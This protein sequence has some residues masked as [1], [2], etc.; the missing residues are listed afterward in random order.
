MSYTPIVG[1]FTIPKHNF[2]S[3]IFS[4]KGLVGKSNDNT[5]SVS[6]ITVTGDMEDSNNK[7]L[8]IKS[9]NPFTEYSVSTLTLTT[10]NS[11]TIAESTASLIGTSDISS[12]TDAATAIK[13]SLLALKAGFELSLFFVEITSSG[14]VVTLTYV[15]TAGDKPNNAGE[16][17]GTLI[18]EGTV[19]GVGFN[20][21]LLALNRRIFHLMINETTRIG[22]YDYENFLKV[23]KAFF[24]RAKGL[25]TG[26]GYASDGY[27]SPLPIS[28][29][30][31]SNIMQNSKVY[32]VN[33]SN[34]NIPANPEEGTAPLENMGWSLT[35]IQVMDDTSATSLKA[36]FKADAF[37]GNVSTKATF[38]TS[39]NIKDYSGIGNTLTPVNTATTITTND[40]KMSFLFNGTNQY[41]TKA[42]P[43]GF[44]IGTNGYAMFVVFKTPATF[45]DDA[46]KT[47]FDKSVNDFFWYLRYKVDNE[48][49]PN[50]VI[51]VKMGTS[52]AANVQKAVALSPNT[53]YLLTVH[54]D[55][56]NNLCALY[57]NGDGKVSATNDSNLTLAN[58]SLDL[59]VFK[60][61]AR[62]GNVTR[63]NYLDGE[64]KEF[65]F[66]DLGS[67]NDIAD[68]PRERVEGYLAHKWGLAGDLPSAHT[69]KSQPPLLTT[70]NLSIDYTGTTAP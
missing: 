2:H 26:G 25:I 41:F 30:F 36:W 49:T 66:Y 55:G 56:S 10:D 32:F 45:T 11:K 61:V 54:K 44:N 17:T 31:G 37:D 59:G 69:F 51:D 4:M 5:S 19:T 9:T 62:N 3:P 57:V 23:H 21:G 12:T 33:I 1:D 13:N 68:N 38:N 58:G 64:I 48:A 35:P 50:A 67:S 14:N 6:T 40:S 28:N 39:V 42:S 18:S 34:V 46:Y 16:P 60:N 15:S 47:I 7:T 43:T 20:G 52:L 27:S 8:I 63:Q 65:I 24:D 53:T 22:T 29:T 70:T